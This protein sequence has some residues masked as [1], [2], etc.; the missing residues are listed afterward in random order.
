MKIVITGAT[1]LIGSTVRRRL[2]QEGHG[3]IAYRM[4]RFSRG[5]VA[6]AA[7][8]DASAFTGADAVVHVSGENIAARWT[9]AKKDRIW[10]SRVEATRA[11]TA[12]LA[13][14]REPPGVLV[15]ASAVGFY[16]TRHGEILTEESPPGRGFLPDLARAWEDATIPAA[17]AGIR[18]VLP[19]I[20]VVLSKEGG[21]LRKMLLPFRLGLGG[22]IGN[23][24][25]VWS[26]VALED[27]IEFVVTA[28][29]ENSVSGVYNLSTPHP[30]TNSEFTR[31]LASELRRPA[32]LPVP[33]WALRLVYGQMADEALLSSAHAHPARLLERSFAFRYPRLEEALR[34]ILTR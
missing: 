27:L 7:R 12:M 5:D 24:Q 29:Q 17:A 15:S 10:G 28:L 8:I 6:D 30:V 33:G 3:V 22:H 1:G 13:G 2:E 9:R 31:T 18:V 21:A 19:R 23:G 16:G 11:L 20:G 34:S 25:Q 4:P 32:V 26:W 14:M